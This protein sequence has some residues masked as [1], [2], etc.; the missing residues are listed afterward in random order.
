MA[1]HPHVIK[2]IKGFG[3]IGL[4]IF[5]FGIFFRHKTANA[6]ILIMVIAFVLLFN[7]IGKRLIK[8]P[9]LIL[10]SIFFFVCCDVSC[11]GYHRI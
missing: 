5:V 3:V 6:G 7:P 8:D 2:W 11:Q 10:G 9:L 1:T 4:F